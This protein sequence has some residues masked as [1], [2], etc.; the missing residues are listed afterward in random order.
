MPTTGQHHVTALAVVVLRR[1]HAPDKT[2]VVHDFGGFRHELADANAWNAG[3]NRAER[4][5][6]VRAWFGIP[7][8]K[9]REATVHVENHHPLLLAFEG[10]G[11]A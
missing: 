3:F 8:F 7:A 10:F 4:T 11:S 5:A 6:G 9:L 2:E 1:V